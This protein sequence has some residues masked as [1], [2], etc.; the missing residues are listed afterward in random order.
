MAAGTRGKAEFFVETLSHSL[1]GTSGCEVDAALLKKGLEQAVSGLPKCKLKRELKDNFEEYFTLFLRKTKKE[2]E[3][4]EEV[5]NSQSE[6]P[7][8]G[9][10]RARNGRVEEQTEG[11]TEV[12]CEADTLGGVDL[13]TALLNIS[14]LEDNEQKCFKYQRLV[15]RSCFQSSASLGAVLD[16][17]G[18]MLCSCVA[19]EEMRLFSE[20]VKNVTLVTGGV[21]GSEGVISDK[22]ESSDFILHWTIFCGRVF[23]HLGDQLPSLSEEQAEEL[24][25]LMFNVLTVAKI[26][27]SST[28]KKDFVSCAVNDCLADIL[29]MYISVSLSVDWREAGPLKHTRST[30]HLATITDL[31]FGTSPHYTIDTLVQM[32][33]SLFT[34]DRAKQGFIQLSR[35]AL[36]KVLGVNGFKEYMK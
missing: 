34:T 25:R 22:K 30:S 14:R 26:R 20:A 1:Q 18:D 23:R 5:D 4:T 9:I 3:M 13:E 27:F 17:W 28:L 33:L 29:S 36:S 32:N 2:E 10:K 11:D 8:L 21:W 19:A 24:H 16:S 15:R 7:I 12:S 31:F 6:S 35:N